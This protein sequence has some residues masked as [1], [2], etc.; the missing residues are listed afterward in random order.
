MSFN[1]ESA[2]ERAKEDLAER[3]KISQSNIETK[4]VSE[5]EFRDMSLGAPTED[6]MAAQMI[7]SGWKIYLI[8]NEED[9]QYR[10]DK[11][12]LRLVGYNGTNHVI[13][14]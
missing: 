6:E 11:Y 1:K 3:L 7:S 5:E 10:A 8:A 9:Y 2:V 4:S 12:H 13:K 14:S